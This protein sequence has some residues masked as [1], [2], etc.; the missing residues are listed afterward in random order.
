MRNKILAADCYEEVNYYFNNRSN[1][2][3][4]NGFA[5][6]KEDFQPMNYGFKFAPDFAENAVN[7]M[8]KTVEDNSAKTYRVRM[9]F[10][11]FQTKRY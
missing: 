2:L 9:F 11:L 8:L 6:F 1:R 5:F 10:F 3:T 4:L 7:S